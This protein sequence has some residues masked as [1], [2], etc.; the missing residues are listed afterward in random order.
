VVS[1]LNG[2]FD[3]TAAETTGADPDTPCRSIDHRADAL[4]VGV[5]R[6]F[7]LIIGVTDVVAESDALA[8]NVTYAAHRSSP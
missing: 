5:E 3:L 1:T 8:A 4:K 2:L 7:G 6:A